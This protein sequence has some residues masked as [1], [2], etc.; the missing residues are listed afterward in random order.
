MQQAFAA[1]QIF[2]F[3]ISNLRFAILHDL[4]PYDLAFF[5]LATFNPESFRGQPATF[6]RS[7]FVINFVQPLFTLCTL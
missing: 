3:D 1:A 2:S 4:A 5:Q 6:N 7:A